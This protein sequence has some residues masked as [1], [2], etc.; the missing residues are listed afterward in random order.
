MLYNHPKKDLPMRCPTLD[1]LPAPPERRKGWPWTEGSSQLSDKTVDGKPWPRVSIVTPSFNQ[2]AFIEETI[3][4]VLLQGYPDL[5]YMIIDGGSTDQTVNII[6]KYERFLKDWTSEPDRGQSEAINKGWRKSSGQI[7][8]WINSDDFYCPGA[9][10]AV[11]D[12]FNREDRTVIVGGA[13]NTVDVEGKDTGVKKDC[14]DLDPYVMLRQCGGSGVPSQPSVFV[15]SK[16]LDEIGFLNTQLHYVMDWELWIRIG[17][18]YE[19]DQ[20]RKT[21]KVLANYRQWTGTKTNK[22][23]GMS[24]QERRLV[25]DSMLRCL[26]QHGEMRRIRRSAYSL[27]YRRQASYA[28]SG[29]QTA[30]AIKCVLRAWYLAPFDYNLMT[31]IL[32]LLSILFGGRA[33]ANLKQG[34]SKLRASIWR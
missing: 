2:G 24:C 7:L 1:E 17:L 18:R 9:I 4:S 13:G 23:A 19:P 22:E 32:F 6:R 29:M 16:I 10:G 12:I 27:T 8:A 33:R 5:E 34:V 15:T 14:P 11:A 21:S 26:P 30:E 28:A 3:R 31:E 20:L 25:L